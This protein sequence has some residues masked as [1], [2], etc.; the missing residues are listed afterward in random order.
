MKKERAKKNAVERSNCRALREAQEAMVSEMTWHL[1]LE[2]EVDT[3]GYELKELESVEGKT[4]AEGRAGG[5]YI[6]A[7][8]GPLTSY[9]LRDLESRDKGKPA[10]AE[11]ANIGLQGGGLDPERLISFANTYGMPSAFRTTATPLDDVADSVHGM[12]KLLVQADG[13]GR[14]RIRLGWAAA[15]EAYLDFHATAKGVESHLVFHVKSL[16][17]FLWMQML[18]TIEQGIKIRR[19]VVCGN[20]MAPKSDKRETCSDACRQRLYRARDGDRANDRAQNK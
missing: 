16:P 18:Y 11:F 17:N 19:C 4:T 1:E 9:N 5:W 14:S 10:F 7:K 8:G 2:W 15:P 13:G 6:V 20:F 3:S 12:R